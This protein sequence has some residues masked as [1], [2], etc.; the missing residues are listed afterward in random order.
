MTDALRRHAPVLGEA[1]PA[2][3]TGL[4]LL[5]RGERGLSLV[6][7]A[8][9]LSV[10]SILAGAMAPVMWDSVGTARTS[11]ARSDVRQIGTAVVGFRQDVG[12]FVPQGGSPADLTRNVRLLAGAGDAPVAR[13]ATA[14]AW[15]DPDGEWL[16]DHVGRN[17]RNYV[18]GGPTTARGWKGPYLATEIGADPWGHRYLVNA[19]CLDPASRDAN[20]VAC[21]VFVLSAG[22]DG[23]VSTPFNQSI[24]KAGVQGDDIGIRLQ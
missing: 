7:V 22:P 18:V 24:A 12:R 20:G 21:A 1:S 17:R 8:I 11:R 9:T 13:D 14:A 4:S 16:D 6:E 2:R 15:L 3:G 10:V 19:W 23:V 5:R